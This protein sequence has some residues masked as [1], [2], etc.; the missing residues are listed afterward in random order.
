MTVRHATGSCAALFAAALL[1]VAAGFGAGSIAAQPPLEAVGT[2]GLE[3]KAAALI[4]SGQ[5]GGELRVSA[6]VLPYGAPAGDPNQ[7]RPVA[8]VAD[9]EGASLLEG[10]SGDV[11][12][13]EVYAYAISDSGGVG[14]FF[15][16]A[17]K[18]E[19]ETYRLELA[20]RGVKFVGHLELAPGD[21]KVQ[22]LVRER[23]SERFNLQSLPVSIAPGASPAA[24]APAQLL[25]PLFL[26]KPE[27]WLL[28][29]EARKAGGG[30]A[31]GEAL[32][33]TFD[34]QPAAPSTFPV[35]R[36][37]LPADFSLLG[38]GLS[39][40]FEAH[41]LDL[42]R[43]PLKIVRLDLEGPA[44]PALGGLERIP[45]RLA[46]TELPPGQY[47]LE[48]QRGAQP[49][50]LLHATAV[51]TIDV[52]SAGPAQVPS[53]TVAALPI[54]ILPAAVPSP[55]PTWAQMRRVPSEEPV[56]AALEE[57]GP[58]G[59]SRS[60]QLALWL[61]AYRQ[62][63]L[64]ARLSEVETQELTRLEQAQLAN[65]KAGARTNLVA[66][67][68]QAALQIGRRQPEALVPLIRFHQ[69][70]Y[71]RHHKAKRYLLATHARQMAVQLADAYV[72]LTGSEGAR[73]IAAANLVVLGGYLL[74][75]GSE[76]SARKAF[77][78]ALDFE[79]ENE[80]ALLC[81]G[82]ILEAD[83]GEYVQAAEVFRHLAAARPKNHEAKLRLAVNQARLGESQAAFKLFRELAETA[84]VETWVRTIAYQEWAS[85]LADE[86]R[87]AEA[88]E[89]LQSALAA[90]P[91]QPRLHL[92]LAAVYDALGRP[93]AARE[94]LARFDPTAESSLDSPRLVYSKKPDWAIDQARRFLD[95]TAE[96]RI[97]MLA[98]TLIAMVPDGG[99]RDGEAR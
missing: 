41:L 55:L 51:E 2:G 57:P 13:I 8:V 94:A 79:P 27:D 10:K 56:L 4:L 23:G 92:Q 14:G 89:V 93:A 22:L 35:L 61:K 73:R 50:E 87:L 5:Q 78:A 53:T 77:E 74:E 3:A 95:E 86:K 65:P 9:L 48:I 67:Q 90:L 85:G 59:G 64:G 80:G 75:V 42:E 60:A 58:R 25:P 16:Q 98:D 69:R 30:A 24:P 39:G 83:A 33:W 70:L 11:A 43:R 29:R 7:P 76:A 36:T 81:L 47:L 21:Y 32:P 1:V 71:E 72:E 88:A 68:L 44:R 12:L 99:E 20:R 66:P 63:L 37:D 84:G 26:E 97:P 6:L 38:S 96:N 49:M 54:A 91:M 28:V 31:A 62:A 45:A 40:P 15:T 52:T 17:F 34:G 46:P 19:L 82:V 18:V